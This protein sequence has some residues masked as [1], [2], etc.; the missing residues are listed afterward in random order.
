MTNSKEECI[1][2]KHHKNKNQWMM[3]GLGFSTEITSFS[4]F[5]AFFQE[6]ITG[7]LE[8]QMFTTENN[9]NLYCKR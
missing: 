3:M 7:V 4:G 6:Q 5:S 8:C 1:R 9:N 2:V